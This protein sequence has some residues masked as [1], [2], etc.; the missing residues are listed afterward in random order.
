M[1][2]IVKHN[3]PKKG[4]KKTILGWIPDDWEITK[5]GNLY[6]F[7]NGL[8]KEKEFFG[9]GTPIINYMDVFNFTSL[10]NENVKGKVFLSDNEIERF[11]IQTG[12]VFFT[13]TSETVN[14][15][16][17]SSVLTEDIENGVFSGFALRARPTPM[18]NIDLNFAKY[19]FSTQL[20]RKEIIRKSSFTTRALTN[21]RFLSEV[22]LL[23]PPQG[24]QQKIAKILS[25]WDKAIHTQEQLIVAKETFKNGLM[26]VLLTGKK[27]FDGFDDEWEKVELDNLTTKISDGIHT[28]PVYTENT[29]IYFVNGNNLK[30]GRINLTENTKSVGDKELLKHEKDLS[31][32]T[33]LLSINGTIGN[34]AYYKGEKI[35]LGKSVAYLNINEDVQKKYVGYQL[36]SYNVLNNFKRMAT[37]STIKN[38]GIGS[39]KKTKI[40]LPSIDEQKKIVLALSNSDKE[41]ELL[42]QQL[43]NLQD[44][45]RGLMQ[46]LLT[47]AVRVKID[48]G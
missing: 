45:K 37:G 14:E 5:L 1:E 33:I 29:N 46:Q 41:I 9:Y 16:A 48:Q 20:A 22:N 47:G 3:N 43:K 36:Q 21:G 31:E 18:N 32:N 10:D 23:L 30:N 15:I 13:R 44:Q 42:K 2:I 26:Q 24:Q 19:C 6:D 35:V 7:K 34:L 12:D 28:T 25:T 4:Y 38:L 8:N 27:R 40:L 39:I 17:Y 11:N